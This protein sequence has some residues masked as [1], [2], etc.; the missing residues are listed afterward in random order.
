MNEKMISLVGGAACTG[1][2]LLKHK[3]SDIKSESSKMFADAEFRAHSHFF[4]ASKMI[5]SSK[6]HRKSGVK[7]NFLS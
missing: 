6:M 3:R 2:T 4:L 1:R 5:S 7:I